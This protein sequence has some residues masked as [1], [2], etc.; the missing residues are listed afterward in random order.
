MGTL[1]GARRLRQ[2]DDSDE[3][4]GDV[5]AKT[6]FYV[7]AGLALLVAGVFLA[8]VLEMQAPEP[9]PSPGAPPKPRGAAQPCERAV[10]VVHTSLKGAHEEWKVKADSLCGKESDALE[11][12]GNIEINTS[13]AVKGGRDSLLIKADQ[14]RLRPEAQQGRFQGNVRI[15]TSDGLEI[16]SDSLEYDGVVGL[17][18]SKEPA[19]FARGKLSG[20]ARGYRYQAREGW[21]ELP[22]EVR[23]RIDNYGKVVEVESGSAKIE[24][25]RGIVYLSDGV[26][27]RQAGTTVTA[28][29]AEIYGST[30]DQS[31]NEILASEQVEAVI[32]GGAPLPGMAALGQLGSQRTLR[33]QRLDISL[34][35]DGSLE[36][37][38]AGPGGAELTIDPLPGKLERRR[39]GGGLL[40]FSFD[41]VE[42][43]KGLEARKESYVNVEAVRGSA[44][45]LLQ[46]VRAQRL[47]LDIDPASG[48]PQSGDFVKNVVMTRGALEVTA[49]LGLYAPGR[50]AF[51][52]QAQ[53]TDSSAGSQLTAE[54]ITI[55]VGATQGDINA[56]GGV[57]HRIMR[58]AQGTGATL[59]SGELNVQSESLSYS[60]RSK[61]GR[62]SG[63]TVIQCQGDELKAAEVDLRDADG[64]RRMVARGDVQSRLAA[65]AGKDG[66]AMDARA[67]ALDYDEGRATITYQ[68]SVSFTQGTLTL[69]TP[70]RLA[71]V[72][73]PDGELK[74][75]SA[76]DSA[77]EVTMG[78]RKAKG[79]TV[80]YTP[81]NGKMLLSG[82]PVVYRDPSF[83]VQGLSLTLNT[84]DDRIV[85]DGKDAQRIRTTIPRTSGQ[86]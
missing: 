79:R 41:E 83:A 60:A 61:I 8:V 52:E 24:K 71:L 21:L 45:T 82:Q 74:Q 32:A 34:R 73:L 56:R 76:G 46:S 64:R 58:A 42:R 10:G 7:R 80:L 86:P 11:L 37:V 18:E 30:E 22:A 19:R 25:D 85:I 23:F 75:L 70:N 67:K 35:A 65:R 29:R 20:T 38:V 13:Y 68:G 5:R 26:V 62:Y 55:D 66:S 59:F 47:R 1:A 78:E 6:G 2:T 3:T 12:S 27:L 69:S 53:L 50:M 4:G 43:L 77:V 57:R 33:C 44:V 28:Q 84:N 17:A 9:S 15:V 16:A 63:G 49:Q 31:F 39:I 54:S 40:I 81:G 48:Q 14:A 51:R 36:E 72:L